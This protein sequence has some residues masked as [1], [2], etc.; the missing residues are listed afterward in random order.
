MTYEKIFE[1]TKKTIMKSD[2]SN[3]EGHLAVQVD[4]VGEGEGAFYIE[5]KDKQLFVEPYEYYDFDCKIVAGADDFLKIVNGKLDPVAALTDGTIRVEGDADKA[6]Q[7]KSII[8]AV[9]KTR[10]TTKSTAAK[11]EKKPAA[12]KPAAKKTTAKAAEK[13]AEE[14]PVAE[15]KA[16]AKKTAA[17][18]A[19][20]KKTTAKVAE[21]KAEEKK[22]PAKKTATK[23][24][25]KKAK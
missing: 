20:E 15:K 19:A 13:K 18:P 6:A 12:K 17:K 16:P 22:A 14:K 8:D 1:T 2:V 25:E 24:T 21:K 9:K 3:I 11:T 4:I 23:T 10:K 7:F 5:L